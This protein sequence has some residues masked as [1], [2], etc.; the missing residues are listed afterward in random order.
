MNSNYEKSVRANNV[1]KMPFL[2]RCLI[3]SLFF[4]LFLSCSKDPEPCQVSSFLGTWKVDKNV[5]CTVDST[6]EIQI[7]KG[8]LPSQIQLTLGVDTL[9]YTVMDCKAIHSSSDLG[10]MRTSEMTLEDGRIDFTYNRLV[11]LLWQNC[12][13]TLVKK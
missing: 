12:S 8:P 1:A 4:P 3:L 5:I 2:K 9:V 13:M 11:L 7:K 10:W 6:N